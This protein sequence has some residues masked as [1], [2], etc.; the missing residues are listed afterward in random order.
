MSKW[1]NLFTDD[2]TVYNYLCLFDALWGILLQNKKYNLKLRVGFISFEQIWHQSSPKQQIWTTAG[3]KAISKSFNGHYM[4]P[5][6]KYTSLIQK[7]WIT[8]LVT[9][10]PFATTELQTL[11]LKLPTLSS[12]SSPEQYKTCRTTTVDGN[13]WLCVLC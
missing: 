4:A 12:T 13:E 6:L 7:Y 11:S 8:A 9:I 10:H 2:V 3:M 5:A 1:I